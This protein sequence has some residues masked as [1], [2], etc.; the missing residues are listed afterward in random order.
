MPKFT[1]YVEQTVT[2][3]YC[4]EITAKDV[5]EANKILNDMYQDGDYENNGWMKLKDTV[6]DGPREELTSQMRI[7]SNSPSEKKKK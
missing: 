4:K 7:I 2:E 1:I 3:V 5:D 6:F